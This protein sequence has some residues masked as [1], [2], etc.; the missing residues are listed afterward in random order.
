MNRLDRTLVVV[1][2]VLAGVPMIAAAGVSGSVDIP[3]AKIYRGPTYSTPPPRPKGAEQ[4]RE[5]QERE[6]QLAPPL[7]R[8][9]VQIAPTQRVETR[10]GGR[11]PNTFTILRNT[12]LS[13]GSSG[14]VSSS[15]NEPSLGSLGLSQFVSHNWF[16]A[17]STDNGVSWS[18]LSPYTTFPNSPAAFPIVS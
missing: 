13:P 10:T 6:G 18:Y 5:E 2:A 3:A 15:V 14:G 9:A 11:A 16:A 8:D 1:L 4:P 12:A 17:R 7:Q